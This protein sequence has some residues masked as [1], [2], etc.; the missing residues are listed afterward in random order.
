MGNLK[1]RIS[2]TRNLTKPLMEEAIATLVMM[3]KAKITHSIPK[4]QTTKWQRINSNQ[5]SSNTSYNTQ[6]KL[7]SIWWV[8]DRTK[9]LLLLVRL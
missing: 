3:V 2:Q 7:Q 8:W 1:S 6:L 5:H 9:L 4:G